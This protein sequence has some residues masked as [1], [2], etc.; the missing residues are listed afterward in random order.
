[1]PFIARDG[2]RL[3]Y[4]DT[5]T[6]SPSLLFVH[7][8]GCDHTFWFRQAPAFRRRHRVV[9]VD[10]RGH[11]RSDKPQQDYTMEGFA[12]DLLALVGTIGLQRP[13]LI[14]HSMG[15][16]IGL[17]LARRWPEAISAVVIADSPIVPEMVESPQ[18]QQF[19]ESISSSAYHEIIDGVV[20]SSLFHPKAEESLREKAARTMSS[21]PQHVIASAMVEMASFVRSLRENPGSRLAVPALF[22]SAA[23]PLVSLEAVKGYYPEMQTGQVVGA[24]H[25]LQME[26]PDQ[27]NAMLRRFLALLT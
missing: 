1:M 22:I 15:G 27:F 25:F 6:G 2:V 7:G 23:T 19:V 11:G 26:A 14:G 18:W 10:L 17:A 24:G 13:V 4:T 16:V 3:F 9:T 20:R 8:W 5:G 12:E 21:A